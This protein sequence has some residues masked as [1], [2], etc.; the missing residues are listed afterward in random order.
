MCPLLN[1]KITKQRTITTFRQAN[2]S[3][4]A[5]RNSLTSTS[6]STITAFMQVPSKSGLSSV[7][8]A[9]ICVSLLS[10]VA[11]LISSYIYMFQG[12]LPPPP[13]GQTGP[14]NADLVKRFLQK[15]RS[16]C[17][18]ERPEEWEVR[19]VQTVFVLFS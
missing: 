19:T 5:G 13:T 2:M 8:V 4:V 15:L 6:F 1:N 17:P 9:M 3:W 10:V 11:T 12:E 16:N 7:V 18:Q 14:E